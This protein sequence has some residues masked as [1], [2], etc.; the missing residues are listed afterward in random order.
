MIYLMPPIIIVQCYI[1]SDTFIYT[2]A[3]MSNKS[4]INVFSVL[5]CI[6][7]IWLIA[8]AQIHMNKSNNTFAIQIDL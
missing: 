7:Y 5:A 2:L 3:A 8:Q 1:Q 6:V 4:I